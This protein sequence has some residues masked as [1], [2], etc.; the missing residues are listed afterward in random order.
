MLEVAA[1]RLDLDREA[2]G[3]WGSSSLLAGF[4]GARL[5]F[6][7]LHWE[8][9]ANNLTGI[10]WPITVGYSVWGGLSVGAL[11]LI[12]LA[13]RNKLTIPD[14]LDPLATG[15]ACLAITFSLGDWLGG[16][17]FGTTSDLF[18]SGRHPVQLYEIVVSVLA[19]AIWWGTL[20]LAR[21]AGWRFFLTTAILSAGMLLVTPFRGDPWLIGNGWHLF[22]L[23]ALVIMTLSLGTLALTAEAT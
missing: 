8:N 12:L 18:A 19:L 7:A 10:V 9:Y 1:D 17:G 5:I 15:L 21:S 13:I 6:V 2:A 22:Q 20:Q 23:I 14:Y 4:V 11:A 3:R 16:P